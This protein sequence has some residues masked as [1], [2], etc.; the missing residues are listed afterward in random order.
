MPLSFR[1]LVARLTLCTLLVTTLLHPAESVKAVTAPLT[2]SEAVEILQQYQIVR[3]NPDGTLGLDQPITRAQAAAIFT[4]AMGHDLLAVSLEGSVP[5]SDTIGHWAAG[6]I[7]VV[8]RVG[9]MRGDGNGLFR[10]DAHITYAEVL[11]VLLRIVNREPAGA[12]NPET[13]RS[14]ADELGIAPRGITISLPAIRGKIFWS[15]ATATTKVQLATGETVLQKY[16]DKTP[17]SLVLD[18]TSWYTADSSVQVKG[19]AKDAVKV[20]VNGEEAT[21]NRSTGAFTYRAD[22]NFGSN[23]IVVEAFDAA[24]N[25]VSRSATAERKVPIATLEVEGPAVINAGSS[26][27]LTIRAKDGTGAYVTPEGLEAELSNDLATFDVR[28]SILKAGDTT[29]RGVLTLT[30]GSARHTFRF[31]VKSPSDAARGLVFA[32]INN[33]LAPTINKEFTVQVRVVDQGGKWLTDDTFRRVSLKA[34]G[35]NNV[36][37]SPTTA[38]TEGGVATFKVKGTR[39]GKF[40]LEATSEGLSET[41]TD[42][43]ILTAT[44]VVL[45]ATP[46]P[47]RPDSTS[48][49]RVTASLQDDNGRPFV[50]NTTNDIRIEL[51]AAGLDGYFVDPILTIRKGRSDS[52]SDTASYR[53]GILAGSV[54]I[55]GNITDGPNYSVQALVLPLVG[56]PEPVRLKVVTP[57][58]NRL[59]PGAP[60][61]DVRIQVLDS[62]N[63]IVTWGSFAFRLRVESSTSGPVVNGLPE[64]LTLTYPGLNYGPAHDSRSQPQSI[65]G[66]TYL[67]EAIVKL[68][69]TKSGSVTITPEL[70]AL[71]DEAY[72]PSIG[73]GPASSTKELESVGGEFVFAGSAEGLQLTVDSGLGDDKPGGAVNSATGMTVRAKVV[74]ENGAPIPGYKGN[75]TLTRQSTGNNVTRL[76]GATADSMTKAASDGVAEFTLQATNTEGFDVY[77][78]I[79]G[80][81]PPARVTVAVRKVKPPTPEIVALRGA[82]EGSESPVVGLVGPDDDFMEIQLAPMSPPNASEPSYWVTAQ[83]YRKGEASRPIFS[84]VAVDLASG[85]PIIRVPKANLRPGTASYYVVINDGFGN[86]DPSPDLGLSEATNAVYVNTYRLTGAYYDAATTRLHLATSGLASSGAVASDRITLVSDDE[87]LNLGSDEVKVVSIASNAVVL[88]LNGVGDSLVP[89]R[90]NGKVTVHAEAGWYTSST[91]Y[92]FAPES[93]SAMLLPA[94]VIT[95]GTLDFGSRTLTLYGTGLTQGTIA[96]QH[97]KVGSVSLQP[98]S[99]SRFDRITTS[100]DNRLTISLSQST[101]DAL[102]AL[103]DVEMVIIADAGWIKVTHSNTTFQAAPLEGSSRVVRL[104]VDV[105][106]AAYDRNTNSLTLYGKGFEGAQV[107]P[108]KLLFR[109]ASTT[110]TYRLKAASVVTAVS[111]TSMTITLGDEDAAFFESSA[112]GGFSGRQVQLNTEDGW[113]RDAKNRLAAAIST[114]QVLFRVP[115]Q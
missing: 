77:S 50:N 29:G 93:E 22:I 30:A 58:N 28:T 31:D 102:D 66:R 89:D 112:N 65:E 4:R 55:T 8:E 47:L 14:A 59:T 21:L 62:R 9:L 16:L 113:L 44:R 60:P 35:T 53:S 71:Q 96:L 80:S 108:P 49:T 78:A 7:A 76:V 15:L 17:P 45:T 101:L 2:E 72:H 23:K 13:I 25:F 103:S 46:S 81:L 83:V 91:G 74:D 67:G 98:G 107:D 11:T 100:T 12:W 27:K 82:S 42:L 90:F 26:N 34:A 51:Q 39:A 5:F 10:P 36:D 1:N 37:V 61:A 95:H 68:A 32:P 52:D 106:S 54:S 41:T 99:S 64:G 43:Q 56:T 38:T 18:D 6:E 40:A 97:I 20:L 105:T 87:E 111:G 94:A 84:G 73:T 24:G 3:G 92:Q 19:I 88:Q 109:R 104:A 114:D 70:L 86:S 57:T 48:G 75:I 33:G 63:R 69:Y 115:A 110:V 79:S 85:L